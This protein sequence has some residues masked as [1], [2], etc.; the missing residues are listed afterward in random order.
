MKQLFLCYVMIL[1]LL[2][3]VN[4]CSNDLNPQQETDLSDAKMPAQ[5]QGSQEPSIKQK[6]TDNNNPDT[7]DEEE[8][9]EPLP[10]ETEPPEIAPPEIAPPEIEPPE[11]EPP[12]VLPP[13]I[14]LL[15]I[16]E[17]RTEYSSSAKRAEYIEFKALQTG[18]LNG[19][20]L[21]IMYNAKNPFIYYFP[22][23]DI[24]LGEYITLHLRTLESVC[25][26][27][28]EDA[29][30]LS[31]GVDSCPTARDLWVSGSTKLLHQTDIVYLQDEYGRILDA[32]IMNKTPS[33]W[34]KNQAHFAEIAENL[35]NA[36]VWKSADGEKPTPFD[37]VD[38]SSIK[39]SVTKSV[40]RYEGLE[41]THTS[42]DW[43]VTATIS[44]GLPNK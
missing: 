42:N 33:T 1:S 35:F 7:S 36:G 24:E 12:I 11:I 20:S 16:N 40:S 2:L 13:V 22:A 27:E 23:A 28:L 18:N 41:N 34:N 6:E 17:L 9:S 43:Y 10:Q 31:G 30:S 38:T 14:N 15:E 4:G 5:K 26:D 8:E 37:A 3:A 44:P 19:L 32:V 39:T 21:H 29:L 25:I